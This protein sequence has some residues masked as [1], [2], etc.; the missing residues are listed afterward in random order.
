MLGL[1]R[2]GH[3]NHLPS[4]TIKNLMER[5]DIVENR[6]KSRSAAYFSS[7]SRIYPWIELFTWTMRLGFLLGF[8]IMCFVI[9]PSDDTENR[10]YQTQS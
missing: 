8:V 1:A 6:Q 9:M 7:Y 4:H 3:L 2:D 10:Q 5:N